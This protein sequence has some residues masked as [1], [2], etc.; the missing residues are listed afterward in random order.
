M[1]SSSQP[2]LIFTTTEKPKNLII[3]DYQYPPN[4]NHINHILE[5]IINVT[6][7]YVRSDPVKALPIQ[8]Y[9]SQICPQLF[10]FYDQSINQMMAHTGAT[11]PT[12][13]DVHMP[14]A[15]GTLQKLLNELELTNASSE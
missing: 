13:R 7:L 8:N 12:L 5:I 9:I 3:I 10:S 1:A 14:Y 2:T 15:N 6:R 11:L 4:P